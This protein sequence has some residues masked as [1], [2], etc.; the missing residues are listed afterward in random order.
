MRVSK[1]DGDF[2]FERQIMVTELHGKK[3]HAL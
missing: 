1:N 2:D 3:L